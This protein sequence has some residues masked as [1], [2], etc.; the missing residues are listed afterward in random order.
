MRL[1]H[2]E[3]PQDP[4]DCVLEKKVTFPAASSKVAPYKTKMRPELYNDVLAEG[5]EKRGFM[6]RP[7]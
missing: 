5:K 4:H 1:Q 2:A 3:S 7:R 6:G